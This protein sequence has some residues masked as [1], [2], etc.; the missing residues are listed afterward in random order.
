[1]EASRGNASRARALGEE[2]TAVLEELAPGPMVAS[3][4]RSAGLASLIAGDPEH[5]ERELQS[6]RDL[7]EGLGERSVASTIAALHARALVELERYAEAER[8]AM[9]GLSWAKAG[10]VVSQAY[11]RGALARVLAARGLLDEALENAYQAVELSS[12]HDALTQRGDALL[13]LALVLHAAA[14]RQGA[15]QAAGKALE[16]YRAKGNVASGDRAA[17]L[18]AD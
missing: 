9:L 11:A 1:L 6:A 14:D 15:Q 12:R 10:D 13:D 8:A 17:R 16:L 18:L 3:A 4:R 5:A 7:L 2:S